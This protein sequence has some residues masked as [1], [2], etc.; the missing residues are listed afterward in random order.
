M[1][2]DLKNVVNEVINKIQTETATDITKLILGMYTSKR[3]YIEDSIVADFCSAI[4]I[5]IDEKYG[6]TD[7]C[8]E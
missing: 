8:Q 4:L 7:T 6:G 3:E 5:A 2:K 1:D